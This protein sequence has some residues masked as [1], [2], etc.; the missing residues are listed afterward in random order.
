MSLCYDFEKWTMISLASVA[1][2]LT[3]GLVLMQYAH[4]QTATFRMDTVDDV[5]SYCRLF[6]GTDITE[7]VKEG[8]VSK[9]FT[10]TTCE[11]FKDIKEDI[12]KLNEALQDVFNA[13]KIEK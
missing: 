11:E 5:L 2:S 12:D 4:G 8:N 3:V 6:P 10:A 7:L 9:L 13:E 1:I